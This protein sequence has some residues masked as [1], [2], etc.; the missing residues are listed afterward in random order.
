MEGRDT[1]SRGYD[2]AAALVVKRLADLGLKPLGD[3]GGWLQQVSLEERA[4]DHAVIRVGGQKL[5]F[6][7]DITVAP[8]SV[9]SALDLPIVYGGY[10]SPSALGDVRGKLVICHGTRRPGLPSA[11]QRMAALVAAGAGAVATISDPSLRSSHRVG[12]SLT[13]EM[14]GLPVL[15]P[16]RRN[17]RVSSSTLP[18]WVQ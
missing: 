18:L 9:S 3:H 7:H 16:R 14:S 15:P 5:A 12:H 2:R 17:C 4:I 11:A 8:S 6:L 1:G 10:C 13:L